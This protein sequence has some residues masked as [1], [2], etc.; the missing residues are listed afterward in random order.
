MSWHQPISQT[1]F[2]VYGLQIPD[3]LRVSAAPFITTP[4]ERT[5]HAKP[6]LTLAIFLYGRLEKQVSVVH[7]SLSDT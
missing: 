5:G 7:S 2:Q 4:S 3:N 1:C 6:L